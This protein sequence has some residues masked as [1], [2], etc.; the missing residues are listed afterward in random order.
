METPPRAWGRPLHRT[1]SWVPGGNTPTG[2]GK[3]PHRPGPARLVWK[4]PHGRGEDNDAREAPQH[5]RETP[6]RAWGRLGHALGFEQA[7]GNTPT[8]VG[9]T[10]NAPIARCRAWKHPH[11]RG[12][13]PPATGWT[14]KTSETPPRAWGRQLEPEVVGDLVGNTPTGVGKTAPSDGG[15][16]HDKKHP[17]GRG[18]DMVIST[19]G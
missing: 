11:G 13:D 4:H 1:A 19:A 15:F 14:W 2:V 6:P 17:H 8:G 5:H 3:T 9:K 16:D 7:D 12:E 10:H 18:E